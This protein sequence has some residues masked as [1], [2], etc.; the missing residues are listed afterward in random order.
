MAELLM[1]DALINFSFTP[2]VAFWHGKKPRVSFFKAL[3]LMPR[4]SQMLNVWYIYLHE[5]HILPLKT[6]KCSGKYT[7]HWVSGMGVPYMGVGWRF[8]VLGCRLKSAR[9]KE[10][11]DQVKYRLN[12]SCYS[13]MWLFGAIEYNHITTKKIQQYRQYQQNQTHN[14]RTT[15][16]NQPNQNINI[17]LNK[18]QQHPICS[19]I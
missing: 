3:F 8:T 10:R 13:S 4:W 18:H 15:N 11:F 5:S 1:D 14:K 17:L 7:I 16:N 9:K 2:V 19:I 12:F 6:A